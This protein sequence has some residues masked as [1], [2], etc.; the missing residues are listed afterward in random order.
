M[1]TIEDTKSGPEMAQIVAQ[2]NTNSGLRRSKDHQDFWKDR[3]LRRSYRDREGRMVKM[4]EW[5]VRI[6]HQDRRE[7]FNLDTANQAV[8]AMKARDIHR[9]L[10]A[11]GWDATLAKYKPD[12]ILKADVCTV[13]DFLADVQAR[14]H[15]GPRTLK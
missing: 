2:T 10:T 5:H 15:I 7:W 12:P 14:S 8:A 11:A 6:A 9:S 4:P 3:L 1:K 13:G